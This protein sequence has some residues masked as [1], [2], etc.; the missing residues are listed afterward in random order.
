[1]CILCGDLCNVWTDIWVL[2]QRPTFFL[3]FVLSKVKSMN[4][5][6]QR[7]ATKKMPLLT[8]FKQIGKAN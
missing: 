1:M 8:V 6:E 7:Q 3:G 4:P 5:F 2:F